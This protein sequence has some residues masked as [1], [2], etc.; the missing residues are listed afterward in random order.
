MGDARSSRDQ[1]DASRV[2]VGIACRCA[3]S[4]NAQSLL[5]RAIAPGRRSRHRFAL[6]RR[7]A[8]AAREVVAAWDDRGAVFEVVVATPDVVGDRMAGPGIRATYF[9]RELAKVA[10]TTLIARGDPGARD[11]FRRADVLIGQPAR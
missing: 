6:G 1:G 4:P 11:A 7:E 10:K 5:R 2:A 9:A 8:D 3:T